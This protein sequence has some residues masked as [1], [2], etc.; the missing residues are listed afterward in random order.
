MNAD[1]GPVVV[2]VALFIVLSP[3]LMFQLPS[4]IRVI[5]FGNMCTSGIAILVHAVIYFCIFTILIMA[6]GVHIHVN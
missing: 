1:W 3:G 5:E 4:R 6:I 2:A